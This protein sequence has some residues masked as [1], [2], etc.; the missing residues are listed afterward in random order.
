MADHA[1][2]PPD[3]V[4]PF[5][6]AA[7]APAQADLDPVTRDFYL[8]LRRLEITH[9]DRARLGEGLRVS[10]EPVRLGQ[11][12]TLAFEAGTILSTET[13]PDGLPPRIEVGFFGVFGP[14][15]PLPLHLTEYAH[16]RMHHA[17]DGTLVQFLN[18]FHHRLLT[19]FYRA[20]ANGQPTVSR[21]RPDADRFARFV[22]ASAGQANR[23]K[24][25][26][27][28][29]IERF[30]LFMARH[31][32]GQTRHP[33]GLQKVL[34][35][36]FEVPVAIEEYVGEM[37]RIPDQFC[38]RLTPKAGAHGSLGRLGSGTRV[39]R[40]VWERQFKFRVVL[41]PMPRAKYDRLLPRGA[42][43]PRLIALVQRYAGLDLSWD[44]R[45]VLHEPDMQ[46][47][48]LGTAELSRTTY[49]VRGAVA[50]SKRWQDFVFEPMAQAG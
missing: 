42:D 29:E 21:D 41:G 25:L 44:V 47:M 11:R 13:R 5:L 34:S 40:N 43:L 1:G 12:P 22:A 18:I 7:W 4:N 14:N 45:L 26:P 23:P 16:Q 49:L 30:A 32:T 39:G 37:L 3:P 35:T 24:S 19:L 20:W 9:R 17:H 31:F 27:E 48:K 50:R 46:P 38:W 6:D 28:G 2:T 33:E 10:E 36:F 8:T 15:G